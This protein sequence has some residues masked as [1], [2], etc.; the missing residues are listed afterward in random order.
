MRRRYTG[1]MKRKIGKK[2]IRESQILTGGRKQPQSMGKQR[3]FAI[4]I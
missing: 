2:T 3:I 4:T 1:S